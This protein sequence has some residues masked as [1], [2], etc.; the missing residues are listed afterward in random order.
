MNRLKNA[1]LLIALPFLFASCAEAQSR[2]SG[3]TFTACVGEGIGADGEVTPF[4]ELKA[5]KTVYRIPFSD[6]K[7]AQEYFDSFKK[8][9]LEE[10]KKGAGMG[11]RIVMSYEEICD[12]HTSG[13]QEL[14]YVDLDKEPNFAVPGETVSADRLIDDLERIVGE[15]ISVGTELESLEADGL[16]AEQEERLQKIFSAFDSL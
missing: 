1:V 6:R 4:F 9:Y 2:I 7:A 3:G 5:G 11:G 13:V 15:F 8:S 12:L 10:E 16:T 14:C